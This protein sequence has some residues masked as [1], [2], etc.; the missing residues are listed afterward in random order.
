MWFC[1]FSEIVVMINNKKTSCDNFLFLLKT[2]YFESVED[3]AELPPVKYEAADDN[4][5]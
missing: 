1:F 5:S 2:A 4:N 3:F